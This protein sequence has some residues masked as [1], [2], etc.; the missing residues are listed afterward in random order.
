MGRASV[1]GVVS[2]RVGIEEG[3][4]GDSGS[5]EV[6]GEG[7]NKAESHSAGCCLCLRRSLKLRFATT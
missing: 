3:R 1:G 7:G 5:G 6:G 4:Q 2:S